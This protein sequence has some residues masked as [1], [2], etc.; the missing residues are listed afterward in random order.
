MIS[1]SEALAGI[2]NAVSPLAP[3]RVR[4]GEAIGSFTAAAHAAT[5]PMPAFDNSAMDG[6][7]ISAAD[8]TKGARLRVVA[9]QPAGLDRHL[10]LQPSE[11]IRIFTGAPLPAGTAAVVMQEEVARDGD[12]VSL[13]TRPED[14]EFIRRRGCDLT[15]G[16]EIVAKGQRITPVIAGL[17]ASQGL[18]EVE[19]GRPAKAA[20]I[21]TGD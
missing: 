13:T 12:F 20:L 2:L 18:A 17:L 14:G 5:V 19:V 11:A 3:V 7:A 1:E 10:K 16:Q 4:L 9:E 15:E 8:L 21:S 6:Y